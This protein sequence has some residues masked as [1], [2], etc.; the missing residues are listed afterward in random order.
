MKHYKSLTF[1]LVSLA[2]RYLLEEFN[3]VSWL[4]NAWQIDNKECVNNLDGVP[5]TDP[6]YSI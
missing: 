3:K 1:I 6:T 5:N 2:P 4:L